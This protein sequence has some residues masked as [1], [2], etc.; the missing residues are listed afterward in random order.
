MSWLRQYCGIG[1]LAAI[2]IVAGTASISCAQEPPDPPV[3]KAIPHVDTVFGDIRVDDYYWMRDR[4]DSSVIDYLAAENEYTEAVMAHTEDLQQKLYDEMLG[5]IKETD[6]SVPTKEDSFYYYT[7]TE[8]G[9]QYALACRKLRSLDASEEMYLDMNALAEG[10]EYFNLGAFTVS[11][12]HRLLAYSIDT[13]GNENYTLVIKNLVTG[14]MLSDT[15]PNTSAPIQWTMDN[16]AILYPTLDDIHRPD[17]L[18]RHMLGTPAD[19]DK[20]IYHEED[21]AFS[22]YIGKSKSKKYL[23]I[24][25]G[26]NDATE[27]R[28]L[29]ADKPSGEFKVIKARRPEVKY[30]IYHHG[31]DFYIHTNEDAQNF[32]ILKTPVTSPGPE[33]WKEFIPHRDSVYIEG[34]DVFADYLVIFERENGLRNIRVMNLKNNSSHYVEFPEPI[35]IFW[36]MSNIEFD[37]DSLRFTYMSLVTPR[38]VYDYNM[39]TRDMVLK[40]QYEV[41]GGYNPDNYTSE[42][43]FATADDGTKIPISLVYRQGL[44]R[45]SSNPCVLRG[46]GSYGSSMEPTFYSNRLSLI[47]RSFVFAIAHVRGG[48]EMGRWWYEQG[49]LLNKRNT[50]TDF[51]A[52]AEHLIDQGYTSK[53]KLVASGAS[54]GGL[55]MGAISNMRPDLFAAIVADV[56]FVDVINTMRDS[57]I[58]LT[59]EEY[60]EWGN[61]LEEEYYEYIMTYSPY[62]NVEAKDYPHLLITAG[63]NDPRVQYWE[64]AKW[65][66]KLRATKTDTNR[67]VLKTNM[68][69]GH[70]GASG[71]YDYLKEVAF[72]YAFIL[73]VLGMAD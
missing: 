7:R 35:Y 30:Y 4:D 10:Y 56:P 59:V 8:E 71:R 68:G 27:Y 16:E 3:A 12:D 49:R 58:P 46:Y 19:D 50:F 33:N 40:K 52:C 11:P 23:F 18:W 2:V 15:I 36:P 57:T 65:A 14:E 53:D 37:T 69:A 62:D 63:I 13:A 61:P 72:E 20:L 54:A 29:E 64:P 66:A 31:D 25:L 9:K 24:V 34:M 51:I 32:R 42:R 5:R 22:V 48:S 41:L 55:L 6:L 73:D 1:I 38:T 67:L 39:N 17:K 21:K 43:I 70:G 28:Y 44:E 47:D 60:T 26:S 45:D